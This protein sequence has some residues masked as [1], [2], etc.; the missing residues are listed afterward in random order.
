MGEGIGRRV[1]ESL[2]CKAGGRG[3]GGCINW[4]WGVCVMMRVSP[5]PDAG[6]AIVTW[7]GR[8]PSIPADCLLR[9][10][11]FIFEPVN[12]D[13]NS[14]DT[15]PVI[16]CLDPS[17]SSTPM[18]SEMGG[19]NGP[20]FP[21]SLRRWTSPRTRPSPSRTAPS[22]T[23]PCSRT[24]VSSWTTTPT[25]RWICWSRWTRYRSIRFSP[26]P[27]LTALI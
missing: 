5:C 16:M 18:Y 4:W 12:F 23:P 11:T 25:T 13:L 14:A 26:P 22:P 3:G 24:M 6:T 27:R 9:I 8:R 2:R 7:G 21:G 1:W 20:R 19:R 15:L 10:P 17:S